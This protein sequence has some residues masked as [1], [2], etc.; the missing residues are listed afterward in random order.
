MT[1]SAIAVA[2]HFIQE[3]PGEITHLKLQKLV[4]ISHGWHLGIFRK[5][6][7]ED[8]LAE[9]WKH[10]PVFPS[11]YH[12][13]KQFGSKP[14]DRLATESD[15]KGGQVIS[16]A[17]IIR[18]KEKIELLHTIWEVYGHLTGPEL[19]NLTHAEGTPWSKTWNANPGL[20]NLNIRN[21]EIEKHYKEK[22]KLER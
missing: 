1:C 20:R 6:L 16:I 8:E 21:E 9:A 5:E 14:I 13:F 12:S 11:I 7:V 17:P 4:Y 10:G 19:S 18:G 22:L 3:H 15:E 2:N